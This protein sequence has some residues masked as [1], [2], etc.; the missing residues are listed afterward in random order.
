MATDNRTHKRALK[1]KTSCGKNAEE[2]EIAT[3]VPTCEI[4]KQK[5]YQEAEQLKGLRPMTGKPPGQ[6]R[7]KPK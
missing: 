1:G 6:Q 4:C 2:V 5:H 7:S 3:M